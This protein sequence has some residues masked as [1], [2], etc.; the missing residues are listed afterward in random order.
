MKNM[1]MKDEHMK[2]THMK[3]EH[4]KGT[5]SDKKI[6]YYLLWGWQVG[7]R[8]E[9]KHHCAD[10]LFEDGKW[11]S[12]KEQVI[13]DHLV[14]FDPTEPE[15]SPYRIGSTSVLTEMEEISEQRAM[16]YINRQSKAPACR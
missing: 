1:R 12:D 7:K 3:A 13:M 2:D 4:M 16:R 10:Y 15:D 5:P 14:G 8:E 6:T 11:V 9:S